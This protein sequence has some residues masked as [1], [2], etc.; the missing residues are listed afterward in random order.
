MT[1]SIG[2][3]WS[4]ID[5]RIVS[6]SLGNVKLSIN[7]D[8]VINSIDNILRTSQGE[9][10][11]LS[12]FG[13]GIEAM[14]F[15]NMNSAMMNWLSREIKSAIEQWDSRVLITQVDFQENPDMNT[16]SVSINF[17]IRGQSGI[18]KYE[19]SFKGEA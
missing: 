8:A 3:I 19:S 13:C 14:L 5:N 10:V 1:I 7:A 4:D 16:V 2:S 6:D 17:A 18:F 12:D 15:E 11:M 9:R